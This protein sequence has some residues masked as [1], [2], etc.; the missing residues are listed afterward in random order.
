MSGPGRPR[1]AYDY[2]TFARQLRP[3]VEL[4][5]D[6]VGLG[7]FEADDDAHHARVAVALQLSSSSFESQM[8]T[9]TRG[10]IAV[11][12]LGHLAELRKQLAHLGVARAGRGAASSRRRSARRGARRRERRRR[13]GSADAASG[14]AW[15]R[16]SSDRTSPSRRDT[17]P[18]T[19][20]RSP[21]SPRCA[22]A[23]ACG[24]SRSRCRGSPSRP[25]SSR[26]RRRTGSGRR[27]AG[28]SRPPSLAVWIG[29]R[30]LTRQTPV[31]TLSFLVTAAAAISATNGSMA[32]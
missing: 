3:A 31:P 32:S 24:G 22:R 11:G 14:P 27:R 10:E 28:R 13:P 8:V 25:G 17:R 18:W 2:A 30:W 5:Q 4:G 26:C 6:H 16:S 23:P 19:W 15:A 29:S 20:S 1:S 7:R 21:S 9:G 12:F